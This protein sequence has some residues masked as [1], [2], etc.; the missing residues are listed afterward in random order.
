MNAV[1]ERPIDQMTGVIVW[2]EVWHL[3]RMQLSF[4]VMVIFDHLN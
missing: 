1:L 4:P 2:R 3:G